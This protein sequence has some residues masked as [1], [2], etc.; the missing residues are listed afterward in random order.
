MGELVTLLNSLEGIDR[1]TEVTLPPDAACQVAKPV[2]SEVRTLP[3]PGLP[4][5]IFT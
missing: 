3:V 2:A 5:V 1:P 4:L